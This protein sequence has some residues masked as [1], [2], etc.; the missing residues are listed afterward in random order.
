MH[1]QTLRPELCATTRRRFDVEKVASE[2]G[3]RRHP[4]NVLVI[5][6]LD[7]LFRFHVEMSMACK[8]LKVSDPRTWGERSGKRSNR[9]FV[10]DVWW[11]VTGS[12]SEV[13]R[14]RKKRGCADVVLV[15]RAPRF[16]GVSPPYTGP[17]S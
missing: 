17:P 6:S 3:P 4:Q 1:G 5:R 7:R 9:M 11:P 16:P 8:L 2:F 10:R 13:S 15:E 12:W 14:P